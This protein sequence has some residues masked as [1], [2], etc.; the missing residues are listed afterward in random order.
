MKVTRGHV[1]PVVVQ[2]AAEIREIQVAEDR[3]VAARVVIARKDIQCRLVAVARFGKP[4]G[5]AV[6]DTELRVRDGVIRV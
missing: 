2:R 4:A 6:H 3:Q 1:G 5:L